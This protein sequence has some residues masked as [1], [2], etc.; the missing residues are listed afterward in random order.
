MAFRLQFS[1]VARTLE[2]TENVLK[3]HRS[4]WEKQ[5]NEKRV[6]YRRHTVANNKKRIL[7]R[8]QIRR[9]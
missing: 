7:R 3:I 6:H 9:Q 5:K 8:R 1:T 2:N 4:D